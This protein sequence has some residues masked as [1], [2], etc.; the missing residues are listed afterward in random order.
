M[1]GKLSSSW[2][3]FGIPL[4]SR[5]CTSATGSDICY[6]YL[7]LVKPFQILG[8]DSQALVDNSH[9]T[10]PIEA[11][12]AEGTAPPVSGGDVNLCYENGADSPLD[13]EFQFYITDEKGIQ[14]EKKIVMNEIVERKMSEHLYVAVCWPEKYVEQYDTRVLSSLPSVFKP[15][16][17]SKKPQETVS[18][19]KC[20]EAFLKEEPLGPEDMWSV[21]TS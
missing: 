4:V 18:L 16:L 8:K 1:H 20:L 2:K 21:G 12:G 11:T 19:Y 6:Q 7:N 5:L 10:A 17:F 15:G 9:G 13:C 14:K 3:P